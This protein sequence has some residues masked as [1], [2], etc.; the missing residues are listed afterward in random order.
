MRPVAVREVA[1]DHDDVVRLRADMAAEMAAL[2]GAARH[3]AAAERLDPDSF[4]VTLLLTQ[5]DLALGTGALRRLGDDVEAKR[6][7]VPPAGRGRGLGRVLLDELEQ[8]AREAGA[9]RMLLHT[10]QRQ[11]SALALYRR[12][13]YDEV[14]VFEPYLSVPES[15]C[16]AK[17]LSAS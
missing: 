4:L 9:S 5:G 15:V 13:G 7:F 10:G 11:E 17:R 6:M 2:Y 14:A 8:R 12:S 16:F 1:T 3:D